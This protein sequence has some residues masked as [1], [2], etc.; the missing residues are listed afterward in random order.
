MW[1]KYQIMKI[2]ENCFQNMIYFYWIKL[3]PVL[4]HLK[5]WYYN[6]P[7][8]ELSSLHHYLCQILLSQ[9]KPSNPHHFLHQF[10]YVVVP[11]PTTSHYKNWIC[12]TIRKAYPIKFFTK[13]Y[14]DHNTLWIN[15]AIHQKAESLRVS[16]KVTQHGQQ[17]LD[18]QY[19][20]FWILYEMIG[21]PSFS[22]LCLCIQLMLQSPLKICFSTSI[23]FHFAIPF[24]LVLKIILTI[25]KTL[26][27][28]SMPQQF[29]TS[30]FL[31]TTIPT[32]YTK[33]ISPTWNI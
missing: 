5:Y 28:S 30:L 27:S 14:I 26:L 9:L 25:P 3:I 8:L 11:H 16:F 10:L 4:I 23:S 20:V 33:N 22:Q 31:C 15:H 1:S 7:Y 2:L 21:T 24:L 32:I 6:S 12:Q 29:F 18:L 19:K 17:Q 13:L